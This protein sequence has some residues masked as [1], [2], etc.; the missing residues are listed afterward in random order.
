MKNQSRI[1][2]DNVLALTAGI[3]ISAISAW[4]SIVGLTAIFAGAFWSIVIMGATLEI[5]KIITV[6]YLYR[7][8]KS[9]SLLITTYFI[10]AVMILM[11]ITSMGTFG[12]L[13]KAH[14]EHTSDSQNIDAKL[15][16]IDQM[17]TR[18]RERIVRAERVQSQLDASINSLIDQ[19][20]VVIGLEARRKQE[21][22]RKDIAER[23]REY[24]TT[25]DKLTDEKIPLQQS[26]RDARREVGPIRYVAELIYGSSDTE[27]MERSIRGIII[28][29]VLVL[30]PLAI[31]LIMVSTH[32]AIPVVATS[33]A[34]YNKWLRENANAVETDGHEWND[35]GVVIR[36]K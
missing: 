3:A 14:I 26:M 11:A 29:L 19:K 10:S 12:Y 2:L 31:L 18:E 1:N 9:L 24:Q 27:L 5:G 25:I 17:I 28:L 13:S 36:K 35:M 16:R 30:D 6:T 15:E 7:N 8:W 33:K 23:I 34:K 22:E 4:Y 32:R 21:S 20:Y